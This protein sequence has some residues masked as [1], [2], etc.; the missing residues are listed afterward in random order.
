[1]YNFFKIKSYVNFV[2]LLLLS[3]GDENKSNKNAPLEEERVSWVFN[4]KI[5]HEMPGASPQQSAAERFKE[6][7][8]IKAKVV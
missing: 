7:V 8:E 4:L 6:I 5:G 1:M 3:C 2:T